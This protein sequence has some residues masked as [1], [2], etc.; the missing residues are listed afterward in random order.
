[1]HLSTPSLPPNVRPLVYAGRQPV[2]VKIRSRRSSRNPLLNM[3]ITGRLL[4]GFLVP[5]LIASFALGSTSIQSQQLLAR[6]SSF[7]QDLLQSN[8]SLETAKSYLQ[9]MQTK[10]QQTFTDA[11]S[12]HPSTETLSGD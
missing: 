11:S 8:T 2:Q 7:Y 6:E 9:L 1:M 4:L 10:I 5:A 12:P 3:R